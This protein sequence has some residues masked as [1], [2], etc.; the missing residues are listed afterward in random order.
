MD[1]GCKVCHTTDLD[2]FSSKKIDICK[3]CRR[4]SKNKTYLCKYCGESD[5]V[6]FIIARYSTCK[7]CRVRANEKSV[8]DKKNLSEYCETYIPNKETYN[9]IDKYIKYETCLYNN[10]SFVEIIE[11]LVKRIDYLEETLLT[12]TNELSV[13]KMRLNINT[14]HPEKSSE[15]MDFHMCI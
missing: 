14:I 7:K 11:K 5:I 8:S 4:N 1:I 15:K 9:L 12:T 2:K 3:E 13:V 10:Q 6:N